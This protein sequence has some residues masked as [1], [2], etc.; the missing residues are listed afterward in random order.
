MQSNV[1]S[2]EA[3]SVFKEAL[4]AFSYD[5]YVEGDEPYIL[6]EESSINPDLRARYEE[7]LKK[8]AISCG[9]SAR[10]ISQILKSR[11]QN[12]LQAPATPVLP[13]ERYT[14][15]DGQPIALRIGDYSTDDGKLYRETPTGKMLI[16]AHPIMPTKRY[17][18][19]DVGTES[20]EI[21]FKRE[22]WKSIIVEKG[23]LS[24]STTIVQ[25]ANHGISVTS[26]T[27]RS[28]VNY[29]SYIDDL[30]RDL[31]P[32]EQMSSHLGWID[33]QTFV[34]YSSGIAYD[35]RGAFDQ[36]YK[37]IKSA[38]SYDVWLQTLRK[39]RK[40]ETSVPVRILIAASFAS[41]LLTHFDALP[42]MVHLWSTRSATGK[43]VAMKVAASVWADPNIGAY[44]RP[45]KSTDVGL[46][47][48]AV[49]TCNMP[50][51]LDEL[52]TIQKNKNFED[53]V[54]G[55]CEGSGKTRGAKN[56][57]IRNNQTWA[58]CIITTGEMPIVGSKNKAG[59]ANR[60]IEIEC[61]TLVLQDAIGDNRIVNANYGYAGHEFVTALINH[62][63]LFAAIDAEQQAIYDNLARVG[64]DKQAISASILLAADHAAERIIFKDGVTLS[65]ADIMRFL[66]SNTEVDTGRRAHEYLIDWAI[67]N[68]A[69]F[70]QSGSYD[71]SGSRLLLGCIEPTLDGETKLWIINKAFNDAMADGGFDP[72]SYL[73]WAENMKILQT[74]NGAKKI[75]KH[76]PGSTITAR[77]ICLLL[78][79]E[80]EINLSDFKQ[81][82]FDAGVLF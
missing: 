47:Q 46:E 33:K 48:L 35:S 30:N 51:C 76:M 81:V 63:D 11:A 16:C 14:D 42:F 55:L 56:G 28:M 77:C 71:G 26:E 78:R 59:A 64:T 45:I 66:R 41:V 80:P 68:R 1:L 70:I 54:Y 39:I 4:K 8:H 31:I 9:V 34:P 61:N 21:S 73:S 74:K 17:T 38:G 50:L 10:M 22:H 44:C 43:T 7:L 12:A 13:T 32:I 49:F 36:I 58:N 6:L 60:V 57:G 75:N 19:I 27:A 62:P 37:T 5:D 29:L 67:E 20:L 18:N 25:L 79:D 23:T 3:I 2:L 72:D 52:Q 65:E 82:D 15:W 40:E 53:I 69:G 24:S